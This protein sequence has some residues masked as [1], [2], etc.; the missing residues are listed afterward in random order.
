M[1]APRHMT[2]MPLAVWLAV[3]NRKQSICSLAEAQQDKRQHSHLTDC[4]AAPA[5][6]LQNILDHEKHNLQKN[7]YSVIPFTENSKS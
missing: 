1:C 2:I 3:E 6:G 4:S 7:I 5:A